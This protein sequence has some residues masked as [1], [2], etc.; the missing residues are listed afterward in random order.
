MFD[1]RYHSIPPG[2]DDMEPGI[3]LAAHCG[4][5]DVHRVSPF[6][7]IVVLRARQRLASH[8][9]AQ[10]YESM[11]SVVEAM[12]HDPDEENWAAEA[13]AAEIRVALRLTRA[14]AD[15]ELTFALE[16][17]RRLPQVWKALARGKIDPRRARVLANA[18][19]HLSVAGARQVVARLIEAA[20]NLTTGQLRARLDRLCIEADPDGA[21]E[22]YEH[23]VKDRRLIVEPSTSG[24]ANLLGLDLAPHRVN[25]VSRRINHL[26]RSL[27]TT[28]ETRTMDQLRADVYLD[29]LNSNTTGNGKTDGNT[30]AAAKAGGNHIH[31]DLDTLVGLAAHPGELHGYGPVIADIARQVAEEQQDTEWRWSVTDPAT[32][33][34]LY[35]GITQRRPN[36]ALRR[37]VQAADPTCVF[38]GC[39]MPSVDCDLDHIKRWA[40][41]G[42]TTKPNL[43]PACRH[44]NLLK[45]RHHWTY[46][47]LPNS[48]YQ[49]TTKLGHTYTTSGTPP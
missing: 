24:T 39:R 23:A 25:A 32:G 41:G 46:Q 44:D 27:K 9:Q 17:Q 16:L 2:L 8:F 42:E 21:R 20:G 38:P 30:K 12:E 6:D 14:A 7:R 28:D 31:T 45:E 47:R 5:I 4:G 29:L 48:T 18:T 26:A 36:A 37:R 1:T 15:A 22:R 3:G 10:V 19:L 11:A 43:A 13:A 33:Q 40:D 49:W 35:D 34:I